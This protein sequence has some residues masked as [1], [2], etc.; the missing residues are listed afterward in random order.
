MWKFLTSFFH[1]FFAFLPDLQTVGC[2][3][4]LTL[5]HASQIDNI[6]SNI[7]CKISDHYGQIFQLGNERQKH[8]VSTKKGFYRNGTLL[9]L[10]TF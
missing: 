1:K 2:I 7:I 9:I 6:F 8:R 4:H 5:P 3:L 10:L